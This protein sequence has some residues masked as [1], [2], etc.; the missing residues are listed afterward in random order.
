MHS[1]YTNRIE[2][3]MGALPDRVVM[4]KHL[5]HEG[6]AEVALIFSTLMVENVHAGLVYSSSMPVASL[7]GAQV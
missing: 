1:D 4:T 6:S 5:C 2:T 7:A 3:A